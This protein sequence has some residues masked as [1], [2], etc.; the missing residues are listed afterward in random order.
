MKFSVIPFALT[1]GDSKAWIN[2][3]VSRY[4]A[5][6]LYCL[7]LTPQW[8][9]VPIKHSSRINCSVN[10][11]EL[12]ERKMRY[13]VIKS[14]PDSNICCLGVRGDK[15]GGRE[16]ILLVLEHDISADYGEL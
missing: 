4:A 3:F 10:E 11:L 6:K 9:R 16:N 1:A 14:L 2:A 7:R 8:T 12:A 15:S 5:V 13:D